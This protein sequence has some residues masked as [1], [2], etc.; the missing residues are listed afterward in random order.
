MQHVRSTYDS[1]WPV[2][3]RV[4]HGVVAE[5]SAEGPAHW[6]ALASALEWTRGVTRGR[7]GGWTGAISGAM[8]CEF[9]CEMNGQV[10][11]QMSGLRQQE[12]R[13]R[14]CWRRGWRWDDGSRDGRE[15]PALAVRID[16]SVES[17]LAHLK[18]RTVRRGC[19]EVGPD[20]WPRGS[21]RGCCRTWHTHGRGKRGEPVQ[22]AWP[23]RAS[24]SACRAR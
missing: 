16:E 10:K 2:G 6:P 22:R 13:G 15:N 20:D 14:E 5:G 21:P 3:G 11:R 9:D 17:T 18:Q 8:R 4:V 7:H 24:I 12:R 19:G 23:T 1:D